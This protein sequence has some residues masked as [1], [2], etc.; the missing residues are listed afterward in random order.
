MDVYYCKFCNKT[1]KMKIKTKHESTKSH[2][3]N[4]KYITEKVIYYVVILVDVEKIIFEH[5]NIFKDR[6]N[7]F[8]KKVKCEINDKL[9]TTQKET[10]W[11]VTNGNHVVNGVV[12][13]QI[14]GIL[15]EICWKIY[16]RIHSILS[17]NDFYPSHKLKVNKLTIQ[18][19]ADYD[20]MTINH[21]L[22]QPRSILESQLIKHI[23]NNPKIIKK[24]FVFMLKRY[25]IIIL[26]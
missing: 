8:I 2:L 6:F 24:S 13:K 16:D 15:K 20:E 4:A 5:A 25:N 26:T 10:Y 22:Q 17:R 7:Q 23:K 21:Y 3:Y 1:I 11:R 9:Y 14:I 19:N 12:R 18:F